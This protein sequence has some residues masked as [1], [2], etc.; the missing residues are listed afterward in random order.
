[1]KYG[2]NREILKYLERA[3]ISNRLY[4]FRTLMQ[5]ICESPFTSRNL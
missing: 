5:L 1:M 3:E 4:R 2:L